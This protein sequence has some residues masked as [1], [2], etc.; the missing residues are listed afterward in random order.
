MIV[1]DNINHRMALGV[2]RCN[3][4]LPKTSESA[5]FFEYFG[6][7]MFQELSATRTDVEK[8]RKKAGVIKKSRLTVDW[9]LSP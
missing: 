4:L 8:N 6:G 1:L 9:P 3:T 7:R 2:K 5:C